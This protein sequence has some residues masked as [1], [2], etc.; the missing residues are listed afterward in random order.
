MHAEGGFRPMLF[1]LE[2]DP[3]ELNDLAREDKHQEIIDLMYQRLSKWS[4]RMSQ[5]LTKSEQDLKNMRGRSA[6]RGVLLGL[7]DGTEVDDELLTR[8]VGKAHRNYVRD[9]QD[10]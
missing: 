3:Q 6:R 9:N 1:D 2:K 8:Y 5:R 10:S 4:I 7:Y